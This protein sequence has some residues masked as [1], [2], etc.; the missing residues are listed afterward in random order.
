MKKFWNE[1]KLRF[2][3]Q[4]RVTGK[5]DLNKPNEYLVKR[6]NFKDIDITKD[7]EKR[8]MEKRKMEV[9]EKIENKLIDLNTMSLTELEEYRSN[10]KI[11]E[12]EEK[13]SDLYQKTVLTDIR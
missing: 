7:F 10:K 8:L 6:R 13:K 9:N 5:Y 1:L 3:E 11:K 4:L 2:K 12:S